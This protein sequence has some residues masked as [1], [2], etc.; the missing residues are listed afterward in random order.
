VRAVHRSLRAV[1]GVVSMLILVS[2]MLPILAFGHSG[3]TDANGGH[4]DNINGGYHYHNGGPAS[5]APVT[6]GGSGG[7]SYQGS[8]EDSESGFSCWPVVLIVVL[9]GI[10]AVANNKS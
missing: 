10:V 8:E 5:P 4:N 1:L 6:A 2:L 9:V 7:A 3:R